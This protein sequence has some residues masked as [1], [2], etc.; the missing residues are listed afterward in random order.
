MLSISCLNENLESFIIS[1]L[2]DE[3][4][5]GSVI[6]SLSTLT[7]KTG[8]SMAYKTEHVISAVPPISFIGFCVIWD[9]VGVLWEN[10]KI[11]IKYQ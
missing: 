9:I 2:P 4:I 7:H 11:K 5:T 10:A 1:V 3:S 8:K 6:F